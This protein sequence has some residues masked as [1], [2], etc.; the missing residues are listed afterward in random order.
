MG[1]LPT[2]ELPP[3]VDLV[4]QSDRDAAAAYATQR[5]LARAV[6]E[7]GRSPVLYLYSLRTPHIA[8]GRFHVAPRG[9]RDGVVRRWCGGRVLPF[10]PGQAGLALFLP[11]RD[12]MTASVTGS[13]SAPQVMN[14]HV[15]GFLGGCRAAGLDPMYPGRD[16]VTI[17]R[18]IVATLGL[19]TGPDGG[20]IFE[21]T[22]A[23]SRPFE[24][25]AEGLQRVDPDG[26]VTA[27]LPASAALSDLER[28]LKRPLSF[29]DFVDLMRRGFTGQ[30]GVE[31]RP[32]ELADVEGLADIEDAVGSSRSSSDDEHGFEAW[33]FGRGASRSWTHR[34]SHLGPGG[35]LDVYFE[36]RDGVLGEVLVS[37][38]F[39][40]SS[41]TV[42]ALEAA[43]CG[44]PREADA[45]DRRIAQACSGAG[46]YLLGVEPPTAVRDAILRGAPC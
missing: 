44:C 6:W 23:L 4:V 11:R 25:L 43:L 9:S 14:R 17:G 38:D 8:L 1:E 35:S 20:A 31:V 32:R 30:L 15:R 3:V 42:A 28:E 29:D 41:V 39:I 7:C 45:I 40:S 24:G 18:R 22:V 37:G 13:L 46:D 33:V 19:E 27:A 34:G 5:H 2:V 36:E 10:G 21:M 16:V 12:A 26:L